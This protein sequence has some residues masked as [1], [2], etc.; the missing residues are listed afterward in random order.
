[1]DIS[2]LLISNIFGNGLNIYYNP[3]LDPGLGD[4]VYALNGGGDLC[5]IGNSTCTN[6]S[7]TPGVPEPSTWALMILG[8]SGIAALAGL[9]RRRDARAAAMQAS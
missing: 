5:P 4:L 1:M 3:S 9:K 6:G 8:F 7:V 2:G